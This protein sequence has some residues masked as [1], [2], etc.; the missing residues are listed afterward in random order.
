MLLD[1]SGVS[2]GIF[3]IHDPFG[4]LTEWAVRKLLV[5]GQGG[6]QESNP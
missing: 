1:Y 5:I 4:P 3:D 6:P 2:F